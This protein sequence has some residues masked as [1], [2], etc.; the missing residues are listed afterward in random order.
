MIVDDTLVRIGSANLNGRSMGLDTECDVF[1]GVD[2]GDAAGVA[3][4][5]GLRRRLIAYLLHVVS[6]DLEDGER[7]EGRVIAAIES[8][9]R[10]Q[11]TLHPLDHCAETSV[12]ASFL[13]I[14]LA[15]PDRPLSAADVQ[16]VL[17]AMRAGRGI[18]ERAIKAASVATGLARRHKW[19]V[20]GVLVAIGLVLAWRLTALR[21][22]ANAEAVS[23]LLDSVGSAGPLGLVGVTG[24]FI[25]LGSLGFPVTWLV[26][27]V[28]AALPV[29]ASIPVCL[30]GIAATAMIGFAIGAVAPGRRSPSREKGGKL[31][32]V[33]RMF[34]ERG[35]LAVAVLRNLPLAPF[36]VVNVACG[37]TSLRWWTYLAG[38]MI[39]MTPGVVLI[40][41]F[42]KQVGDL[43]ENPTWGGAGKVLGV[44]VVVV[45]LAALADRA[46][47]RW[48][49][50]APGPGAGASDDGAADGEGR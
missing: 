6:F 29:Y 31:A 14:E 44:L 16:R 39:G 3:A 43:I 4:I 48:W 9:R 45:V 36:A 2:P 26:V 5:A 40:A 32:R 27:G 50:G 10:G 7:R 42:G 12:G 1:T 33:A 8:L 34:S 47:R 17:V 23:K 37:M 35:V 18:S 30:V 15:D 28:A 20:A 11:R 22:M 24:V 46:I 19:A 21:E 41:L 49:P 38:T 25:A 13:P